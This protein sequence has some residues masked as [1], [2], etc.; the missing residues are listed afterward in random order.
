MEFW[1]ISAYSEYQKDCAIHTSFGN[2]ESD[3]MNII[4]EDSF[5][6]NTVQDVTT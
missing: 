2:A 6:T 1:L 5:C 3:P 4:S